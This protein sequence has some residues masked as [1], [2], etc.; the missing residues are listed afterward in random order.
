MEL[1]E[2]TEAEVFAQEEQV[3]GAVS[4]GCGELASTK[5]LM[6]MVGGFSEKYPRVTFDIFTA[7]ADQIKHRWVY[8]F[9]TNGG[10]IGHTFQD[11]QKNCPGASVRA[12][13]NVRFSEDQQL[14]SDAD[15]LKWTQQ[16]K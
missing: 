3:E 14:T 2:K 4:I 8:P 6:E 9:A 13:L 5:L 15:I 7:N 1:M 16:I 12:G 10:W 11:F